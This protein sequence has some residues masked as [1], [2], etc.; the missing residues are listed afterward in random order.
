M[1]LS[2]LWDLFFGLGLSG[3]LAWYFAERPSDHGVSRIRQVLLTSGISL[4]IIL[5]V[6]PIAHAAIH[7]FWIHMVQHVALMM[8]ISPLIVLGSPIRIALGSRFNS[9]RTVSSAL[10]K[11]LLIRQLFRPQVGF[12]LFLSQ[13][14]HIL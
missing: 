12:A 1:G 2:L 7:T 4:A 10:A 3:I 13:C 5:L 11:N 14:Y 9:V 6:G 8:L